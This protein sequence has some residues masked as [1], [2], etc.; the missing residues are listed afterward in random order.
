MTAVEIM[1]ANRDELAVQK[2]E[3]DVVFPPSPQPEYMSRTTVLRAAS[4][5][6]EREEYSCT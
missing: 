6:G 5:H 2:Q 4:G 1:L 3:Y